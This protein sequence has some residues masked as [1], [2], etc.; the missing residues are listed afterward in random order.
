VILGEDELNS[1]VLTVKTFS[2]GEQTKV[3]RAEL[4]QLLDQS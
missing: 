3:V 2:T 4:K 1:G